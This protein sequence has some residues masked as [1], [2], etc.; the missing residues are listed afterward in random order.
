MLETIGDQTKEYGEDG[1]CGPLLLLNEG[2]EILH[3]GQKA[4]QNRGRYIKAIGL[5]GIL[6]KIRCILRNTVGMIVCRNP[7]MREKIAESPS[8]ALFLAT[9]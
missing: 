5:Q 4:K 3:V 6:V 8:L 9:R 1:L 2:P 7:S